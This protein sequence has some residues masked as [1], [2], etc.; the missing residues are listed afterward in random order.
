MGKQTMSERLEALHKR[1]VRV[2]VWFR[3]GK[4][5]ARVVSHDGGYPSEIEYRDSDG[6]LIG[7]WAFGYFDPKLPYQG[8]AE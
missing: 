2:W 6:Y 4:I 5:T 1:L 3:F 7:Y 8:G